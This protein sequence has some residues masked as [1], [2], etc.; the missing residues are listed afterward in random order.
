MIH[1]ILNMQAFTGRKAACSVQAE[2]GIPR[3][4]QSMRGVRTVLCEYLIFS[5]FDTDGYEFT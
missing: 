4:F 3:F 5:L 1:T 2:V